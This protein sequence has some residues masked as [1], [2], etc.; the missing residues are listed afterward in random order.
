MAFAVTA[1][2]ARAADFVKDF[3]TTCSSMS[4]VGRTITCNDGTTLALHS[5]VTPGCVLFALVPQGADYSLQC[6]TPN[7]T[8]LWWRPDEDGRG[9]WVSH[10]GNTMFAVDYSYDATGMAR[11]RTLIGFK[12][13][14]G[15]F[16]G[17]VYSTKGPSFQAT[18]DSHGVA[19]SL[20][21][22]GWIALDDA[23]HLRV[24]F[25]DT[26][27][28]ALV[29]QQFGPLPACAFGQVSDLTTVTNY[30]D[31]W[32]NPNES[33]WG[34]NLAHQGDTIFAAWYTYAVDGTPMW[35][36][37][38]AVKTGPGIYEGD[39]YH[40]TGPLGPTL[41]AKAVGAAT[42]TFTNGN[43]ATFASSVQLDGMA[44]P[45]TQVK[46]ISRQVF[47]APGAACR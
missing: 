21:G 7:A 44:S 16:T 27:P 43:S 17:N 22:T 15:T 11:W 47:T 39:L 8:G 28:R 10:Q 4:I 5:S 42:F 13:P 31:L 25:A 3:G 23:D 34:I 45:V 35:L 1:L 33:G 14:D 41:Q 24:N 36:V 6:L 40:T 26:I 19:A 9:T 12:S 29:R 2:P 32:W 37:V 38:T 30:T 46:A 20:V 18:F